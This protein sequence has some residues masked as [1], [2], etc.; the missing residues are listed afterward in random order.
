MLV[1]LELNGLQLQYAQSSLHD[2]F[3]EIAAGEAN[4][5]NLVQWIEQHQV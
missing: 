1:F 3:L 2:I 5:T 4:Y